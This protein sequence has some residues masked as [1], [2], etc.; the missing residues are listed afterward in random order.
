MTRNAQAAFAALTLSLAPFL[1]VAEASDS[2]IVELGPFER[3]YV[4]DYDGQASCA[5]LSVPLD[6]DNVQGEKLELYVAKIPSVSLEPA[7]PLILLAGGPG[8]AATV[9]GRLVQDVLP[10]TLRTRDIILMDQRGTGRSHPLDCELG[11][12]YALDTEELVKRVEACAANLDVDPNFF[13][14]HSAI[15]DIDA[16]RQALG[17]EQVNL[18][19]GS[20]G[21]RVALLYSSQFPEQARSLILDSVTP[22]SLS[23][24]STMA[25]TSDRA[26]QILLNDCEQSPE[27]A[28]AFPGLGADFLALLE[29]V[30]EQGIEVTLDHPT[31]GEEVE[32]VITR[33]FLTGVLHGG[34]YKA[35]RRIQLPIAMGKATQGD[36]APLFA[37]STWFDGNGSGGIHFGLMLSVFCAE[38]VPR[39]TLEDAVVAG[40]GTISGHGEYETWRA[41][42]AVWPVHPE[43]KPCD[44]PQQAPPTLLL[45]GHLDPVTPPSLAEHVAEKIPNSRLIIVENRGH[46]V[47]PIGCVPKLMTEFIETLDL[48]VLDASCLGD[49]KSV[50]FIISSS[51]GP[52]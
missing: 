36:F 41:L 49:V 44:D 14:T 6:W 45:S 42:C 5:L 31:T 13:D 35:A 7:E 4:D 40:Q 23:I 50:P 26:F 30:D 28:R 9:M 32:F 18:L 12:S 19:G 48:S 38:D 33:D 2:Q 24:Y 51:G 46:I 52:A 27:C 47:S 21:T 3:C 17:F 39:F 15:R 29:R 25:Q 22:P 8:Q 43:T 1:S 37:M 10:K 20:Y 34:L 11:E 16:L